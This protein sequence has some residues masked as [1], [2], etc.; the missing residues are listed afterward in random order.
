MKNI[1]ITFGIVIILLLTSSF[2]VA[3]DYTQKSEE[4][5]LIIIK[6]ND[7]IDRWAVIIGISDYLYDYDLSLCCARDAIDQYTLLQDK[8]DRWN[9]NNM[10][11]LINETASKQNILNALDWL[12]EN[13]DEG[14]IIFFSYCGHGDYVAD[15]PPRDEL[16]FKDEVLIPYDYDIGNTNYITDDVLSFKFDEISSKGVKGM[17][18]IFD[19]CLSGGLIK[20]TNTNDVKNSVETSITQDTIE[21]S[22][23]MIQNSYI[24]TTENL[25]NEESLT[26]EHILTILN[27]L[28][29]VSNTVTS[30]SDEIQSIEEII[31]EWSATVQDANDFTA[32]ITED[33]N[34]N[35]KVILTASLPHSLAI[36]IGDDSEGVES[37]AFN[38]GIVKAIEKGKSTAEDIS[39]YA[40]FWWFSNPLV[41]TILL[42]NL[43][44]PILLIQIILNY[45]ENPGWIWWFLPIPMYKD[46]YPANDPK[47]AKL[48]I[49]GDNQDGSQSQPSSQFSTQPSD[50]ATQ[51]STTG[52]TTTSSSSPS[53]N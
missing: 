53:N 5:E 19:S 26:N 15:E 51:Q 14:D 23:I 42:L 30:E 22:N 7:D 8:D 18:L 45:Y 34:T 43:L 41:I 6:N 24:D 27:Q 21:V 35:N 10:L 29:Q 50:T 37:I 20:W 31:E 52:S 11:L 2:S 16:D 46:R 17:F 13:A 44:P 9:E 1:I 28:P 47:S 39:Q 33:I 36:G 12:K 4:A 25:S 40:K 3:T 49:I 48:S 32:G 38:T